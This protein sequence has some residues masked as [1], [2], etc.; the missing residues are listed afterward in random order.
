MIKKILYCACALA[1][2]ITVNSCTKDEPTT[3]TPTDPETPTGDTLFSQ[4]PDGGFE[5]GWNEQTADAGNY[6]EYK[7]SA[8]YT[9]NSLHAFPEALHIDGPL[10]AIRDEN[11]HNGNYAM[12]LTTLMLSSGNT[13]ILIPGAIGTINSTFINDFLQSDGNIGIKKSY[14]DSPTAITG[15]YKYTPVQ[16]DSASISLILYAND[17]IVATALLKEKN[18]IDTWT[19]FNVPINYTSQTQP[20][21]IEMIFS[22]SAG[23]N[24]SDLQHCQGQVGSTLYLDDIQLT[25]PTKK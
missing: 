2:A 12:K 8:L 25:L 18:T 13:S 14:T 17:E 16:G 5:T 1:F 15:Y 20:T 9:L 3:E 21:H 23:Y 6:L 11:A 24:F 10:T 4:I 22:A 7:T 19:E